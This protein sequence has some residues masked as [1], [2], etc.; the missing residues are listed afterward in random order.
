MKDCDINGQVV[1]GEGAKL[2]LQKCT[3][4][5]CLSC[6]VGVHGTA[7][8]QNC[9]IEDGPGNGILVKPT[10]EITVTGTTMRRCKTGLFVL[11]KATIGK[12][13]IRSCSITGC[14]QS[15]AFAWKTESGPGEVT[16]EEG[17]DLVCSGNNTSDHEWHGD[18]VAAEGGTIKGVAEEKIKSI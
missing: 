10:G 18:F 6:A 1:V 8:I 4:R 11:G 17:A 3:V 14:T 15:G 7:D 9:I 16:A 5:N 13:T 2:L 12:A